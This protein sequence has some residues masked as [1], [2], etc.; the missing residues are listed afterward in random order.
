MVSAPGPKNLGSVIWTV[1]A[2]SVREVSLDDCATGEAT[3]SANQVGEPPG[4]ASIVSTSL[5]PTAGSVSPLVPVDVA[6]GRLFPT[7]F[8]A[9]TRY[10]TLSPN[11]TRES[12]QLIA[13]AGNA[14]DAFA[15][16]PLERCA[17]TRKLSTAPL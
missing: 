10:V 14:F 12:T 5:P 17:W 1:P 9:I 2:D 15:Q 16:A 3:S 13:V 6:L 7:E 8:T 4:S 11:R